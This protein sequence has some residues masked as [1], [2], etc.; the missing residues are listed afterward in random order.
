MGD[1]PIMQ[2]PRLPSRSL[3][4]DKEQLRPRLEDIK[5]KLGHSSRDKSI[6]GLDRRI[7]LAIL[8][9]RP[10]LSNL[11]PENVM[12]LVRVTLDELMHDALVNAGMNPQIMEYEFSISVDGATLII[13]GDAGY[14]ARVNRPQN[15]DELAKA[16]KREVSLALQNLFEAR[17]V[18]VPDDFINRAT[19]SIGKEVSKLYLDIRITSATIGKVSVR[20]RAAQ[21]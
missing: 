6:H 17:G 16:I 3:L 5:A 8:E 14:R 10:D 21:K 11:G 15:K 18:P 9:A 7:A 13:T 4:Q 1:N 20:K 12:P 2:V 19:D